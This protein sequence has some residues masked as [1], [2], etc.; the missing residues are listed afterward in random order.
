MKLKELK[1][2]PDNPR[3]IKDDKFKKL[4]KS[5]QESPYLLWPRGIIIDEDN[6]VLGGN[7]RF[8]ACMELKIKEL[9]VWVFTH[10]EA[11]ENNKKTGVE[12]TYEEYCREIIAK[13]NISSG[14]W[15]MDMLANAWDASLLMDW[16][17]N[18]TWPNSASEEWVGMPE[19]EQN[20]LTPD[21]QLIVSFKSMADRKAFGEF[22]GQSITEKTRSIWYPEVPYEPAADKVYT[23]DESE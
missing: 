18:I 3:V 1:A 4:V 14:E 17:L 21:N 12:R 8:R 15:D 23:A 2:N 9:D 22:I 16:G 19:F 11:E 20:D 7:Q 6:M 5:I 13:D 10:E